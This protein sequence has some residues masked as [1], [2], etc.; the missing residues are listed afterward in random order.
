M[1]NV[2]LITLA[3]AVGI[4]L[5]ATLVLLGVS[6]TTRFGDFFQRARGPSERP[7]WGG[8]VILIAFAATPFIASAFSDRA[9]EFFSPKSGE[10]LAYLG[11]CAL[12]FAI[13]FLDDWKVLTWHPRLVVQIGAASAVYAAGY[14]IDHVGLPWGPE[15]SLGIMAPVVTVLWIVFFTNAVNFIDG[16]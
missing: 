2:Y 12:I 10:F 15:F 11:A 13:G 5:F 6:R 4:G 1:L 3:L 7:R 14:Q 16:P 8:V 9:D